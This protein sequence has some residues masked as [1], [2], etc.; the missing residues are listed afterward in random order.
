[1]IDK[2]D[3]YLHALIEACRIFASDR[4]NI[5]F[6]YRGNDKNFFGSDEEYIKD[7]IRLLTIIL[8]ENMIFQIPMEEGLHI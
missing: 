6:D 8:Q 5:T 3:D 4:D 7:K 1:M 2:K